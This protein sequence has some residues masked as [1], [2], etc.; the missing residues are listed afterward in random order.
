MLEFCS[1]SSSNRSGNGQSSSSV[2]VP[3]SSSSSS[4]T[5]TASGGSSNN[6][7]PNRSNAT[8]NNRTDHVTITTS[9]TTNATSGREWRPLRWPHR[10][11]SVLA[12]IGCTLGL[13]NICRF[14]LLSVEYGANFILQ[15]LFLSLIFGIPLL[16]FHMS[17]GQY[18][19]S[20]IIDMWKISPIFK[21]GGPNVWM[22]VCVHYF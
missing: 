4:S 17:I 7:T 9:T 3:S 22:R 1:L 13:T 6:A 21:V 8:G 19:S 11:S 18:L 2:S 15:F 14:S 5:N 20:G 16:T 10:L 12:V